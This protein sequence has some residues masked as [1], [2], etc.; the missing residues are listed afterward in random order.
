MDA[1]S[2]PSSSSSSSSST[3]TVAD[4]KS[5]PQP[6][7]WRSMADSNA[8]YRLKI[9]AG[10]GSDPKLLRPLNVNDDSEPMII[11]T[12]EFHGYVTFRIKDLDKAHGYTEGQLEDGIKPVPNSKW[13]DLSAAGTK[14]KNR[15]NNCLRFGGRFKREW[16]GD[17]II[18]VAE[19]DRRIER[20]PPCTSAGIKILRLLDPA[21]EIDLCCDKP[22]IRSPLMVAMNLIH[23]SPLTLQD[24]D[25][26]TKTA[27][28][29][30]FV[31]PWTSPNGEHILENTRLLFEALEDPSTAAAHPQKTS[32]TTLAPAAA[33]HVSAARSSRQRQHFFA[34]PKNLIRHR[35]QP[36][37]M[38]DFEFTSAGPYLD[39]ANFKLKIAGFSID[40]LRFWDGQPG[41][42]SVRTADSSVTFF[43]LVMEPVPVKDA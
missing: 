16:P 9:L 15:N 13:F 17:Q 38:Y 31:P 22:Y 24:Q 39:F 18:F 14:S 3:S 29:E 25:V 6:Y 2:T 41:T 1:L 37:Q 30:K 12:D 10:P 11:D 5:T 34:K 36:D 26:Q 42:M 28:E 43:T 4:H 27:E 8:R 21:V 40:L 33:A 32:S 23:A 7:V 19:F 20:L 35:Y